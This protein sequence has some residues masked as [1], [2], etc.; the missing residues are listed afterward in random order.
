MKTTL[1]H[2]WH[3]EAGARFAPFAGFDMPIRYPPGTVE[4][5]RLCRRSAGLFDIDHMGRF[6]LSGGAAGE[7]LSALVSGP[8]L[9][10]KAGEARY[11][12]LLN[13]GG[14]IIDD[15]FI[16]RLSEE[17]PYGKD[18][19]LIV[20]NAGN[21]EGD[22]AWFRQRLPRSLSLRDISAETCMIA[23]Q[24]PRAAELLDLLADKPGAFSSLPR[25][26]LGTLT[27]AGISVRAGRTGYTG[28]DGAELFYGAGE[29]LSLWK[30]LLAK[31]EEAGIEAG[32]VGLAARDSLRFEAGMPL[33]GH[34]IGPGISPPE[35]LLSWACDFSK[36]FIGK[37]ALAAQKA[38]G[39]KRKL[40]TLNVTGGVPREGYRVLNGEGGEIGVVAAGMFCPTVGTYSANAFVPPEYAATGTKLAVEIRGNPKA[41]EVVKRP[42]YTP[43]YRRQKFMK[44]VKK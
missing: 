3:E 6:A 29:A 25:A 32:P 35:A 17:A 36:D 40:V 23:V 4:E 39:L 14:G 41:A 27:L 24:G 1:L 38:A 33:H 31:A 13:E 5:H 37:E 44:E 26:A 10:M 43:V 34:E 20:V 30:T 21:R 2:P 15:L 16:Y 12:L 28:E 7:A 9:D 19:W 8:V 42:L 11:S 22:F 18:P